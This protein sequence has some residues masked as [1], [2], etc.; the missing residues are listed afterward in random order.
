MRVGGGVT[1][2][3]FT[4]MYAPPQIPD[5]IGVKD[6]KF[7]DHT[8]LVRQNEA[9][10]LMRY[11]S[12]VQ[13][14]MG[15]GRYGDYEPMRT[16]EAGKG[17]RYS[18]V[19]LYAMAMYIYS[20]EPPENPNKP[21]AKSARG[22]RVFKSE[23]CGGCHTPPIYT[24]NKLVPVQGFKGEKASWVS[25]QSMA[26]DPRTALA[27]K[28]GTGYYKVPS[29]LGVWYRSPFEHNGSAA[30]LEEWFD[31][32]RLSDDYQP[33]GFAG[34]DGGPRAIPGHEFGLDLSPADKEALIAFLKTL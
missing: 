19:Q 6:R 28:K 26:A 25:R 13:D 33:K 22:E 23:R 20:L 27:T 17:A 11:S 10:D 32:A 21:D 15:Y 34:Y 31:K 18:D 30:T 2:R 14:M 12:L 3:A 1:A 7:L 4:S 16:P 9:A 5:L 29:L 24:N 8:G